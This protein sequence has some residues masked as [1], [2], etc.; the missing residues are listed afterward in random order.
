MHIQCIANPNEIISK[1]VLNKKKCSYQVLKKIRKC[2]KRIGTGDRF[3]N[4][5]QPSYTL[6]IIIQKDWKQ[7]LG[8]WQFVSFDSVMEAQE[9]NKQVQF[10]ISY[11]NEMSCSLISIFVVVALNQTCW[12]LVARVFLNLFMNSMFVLRSTFQPQN[13]DL[14]FQNCTIHIEQSTIPNHEYSLLLFINTLW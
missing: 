8:C 7:S 3:N 4:H 11:F 5:Q 12:R 6:L 2:S 10:T 9:N 14:N 13:K 1:H